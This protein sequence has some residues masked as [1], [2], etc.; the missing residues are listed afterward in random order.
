MEPSLRN[1]LL[2][3]GGFAIKSGH[4]ALY[5]ISFS[6]NTAVGAVNAYRFEG[7]IWPCCLL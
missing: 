2:Q 7:K 5:N 1:L 6:G 3:G 4:A